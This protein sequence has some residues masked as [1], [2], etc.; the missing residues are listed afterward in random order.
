MNRLTNFLIFT[1]QGFV[2]ATWH[3]FKP[4]D[5]PCLCVVK[6]LGQRTMSNGLFPKLHSTED[7]AIW[8]PFSSSLKDINYVLFIFM[9][10][11]LT[12]SIN[13]IYLFLIATSKRQLYFELQVVGGESKGRTRSFSSFFNHTYNRY[14]ST[15]YQKTKWRL[16]CCVDRVLLGQVN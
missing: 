16:N 14:M 10:L 1:K 6:D 7:C 2:N 15:W 8:C 9:S 4:E 3:S 5:L 13:L 12:H 11:C